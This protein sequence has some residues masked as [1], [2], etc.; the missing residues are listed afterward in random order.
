MDA[1]WGFLVVGALV[2]LTQIAAIGAAPDLG[3]RGPVGP[4]VALRTSERAKL[5]KRIVVEGKTAAAVEAAC[6]RAVKEGTPVVFV[7]AGVYD[8]DATVTV[9]GGL[10]LLGEGTKTLC[11]AK[12]RDVTLFR[13]GGDAVRFTRLKLQGADTTPSTTNNTYGITVSGKQN[14]RIDHCEL[15]GFSYAT[16]FASEA[17]AQVDHCLIHHNLR[18]GLGYGVAIYSG[19]YVLVCDNEF[20]QNRHSLASNG[21]LDWSSPKRMGKYVHKP[22]VRKTHWEF[23]HNRVGSN[24]K[25]PYELCAVDTHPGMDGTFVVEGNVF[26][27]LRH[28]VGIRDGSG[29]IQANA[30]RNLRTVTTFRPRIA[31]SISYGRHNNV[32]VDGCMPH[33]IEVKENVFEMKEGVKVQKV[34]LG[35]AENVTIDGTLAPETRT[36]RPAPPIPRLEPMGEEGVLRWQQNPTREEQH[37]PHENP[38]V[39]LWDTGKVYAQKNPMSAAWKDRANWVQVPYGTTDYRA[40]GDL[41]VENDYLCLFLFTNKDDSVDLMAKLSTGGYKPNEIYKVHDTGARNFGHGTMWVQILKNT[42]DEVTVMHAGEGR[43]HGKPE[44]VITTYRVHAAKPWLEVRPV[45]RVNQQGMHGKSRICAFVKDKG[46]DFI[47]DAKRRPFKKEEILAAPDGTIGIINFSRRFRTDYDFMWFMAF[48]PG[49]EKHK[50]TYLGFHAD[51]FWEDARSDRPSVGAQYASLDKGLV[52]IGVL[53]NKDNWKREDVGRRLAAG[54]TYRT[55]FK[56]PYPGLWKLVA[57]LDGRYVH[58]RVEIREAGQ[59]FIFQSET[60]G[61]LDYVLVYLWDRTPTA[62]PS[63]FTPMD[64]YRE[65]IQGRE[66]NWPQWRGPN[67]DGVSTETGLLK[68]WPEG[69]PPLLWTAR[70]CG[71]GFSTVSIVNGLIYTT[72]DTRAECLVIALD[73]D[74]KLKWGTPIG[75][76]WTKEYPGARTIPTVS[77]GRVYAFSGHGEVACLDARTGERI[78]WRDAVKDFGGKVIRWGLAESVLVDGNNVICT[79]G[80]KDACLVAL[81]KGTGETVWTS[82]GVSDEPG[83][84][85]PIFFEFGGVRQV[86]TLTSKGLV[87]VRADTGE[88]LWRYAPRSG[89]LC[90]PTP[91]YSDGGV[92]TAYYHFPGGKVGLAAA[93]AQVTATETWRTDHMQNYHGGVVLVNGYLYGN[94]KKGWSCIDFQT[95]ELMYSSRGIGEGSLTCADGMLYC[96]NERGTLALVKATPKAYTLVSQFRIPEGGRGPTWAHPVVCGGRLYLRHGDRLYAFGIKTTG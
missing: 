46:E 61:L 78:W 89:N 69:G 11:R 48:P 4:D 95:G 65:A 35:K 54:G 63:V 60:G 75:R 52:V 59:E 44:P 26:E 20:S 55:R 8:F 37:E 66:G 73:L 83:Y 29:I 43:R 19:A 9:P 22:G 40:R 1:R 25:S 10:T 92:F 45:Q 77:G 17:T 33:N 49:A 80:G 27:N 39:R 70:G 74:G 82:K 42:P 76:A 51:P 5:A 56:A 81:D 85:S 62:R 88:F 21:A 3:P 68:Q 18:D 91:I 90:V 7:P 58:S 28:A 50:L 84:S 23:L 16:N 53:N 93:D 86:V 96:L 36:K 24:D 30:F 38:G 67:R 14:I 2:S 15:L 12:G 71:K 87:A 94:H 31:I 41:M 72:G 13:V 6:G 34:S 47:L 79:P 32:P 57:R 64:V